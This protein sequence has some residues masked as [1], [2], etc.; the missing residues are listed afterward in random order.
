MR[1]SRF[2]AK[3]SAA[4]IPQAPE[5]W[6]PSHG[7]ASGVWPSNAH[8]QPRP[9]GVWARCGHRLHYTLCTLASHGSRTLTRRS[10]PS[11]FAST[12]RDKKRGLCFF[13]FF[14]PPFFFYPRLTSRADV[15]PWRRSQ[16]EPRREQGT[17]HRGQKHPKD[18][19]SESLILLQR[20]T[21][22]M[23]RQKRTSRKAERSFHTWILKPN[24]VYETIHNTMTASVCKVKK[25]Q[26][27]IRSCLKVFAGEKANPGSPIS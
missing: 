8:T 21:E 26:L 18:F 1:G 23:I 6:L 7:R 24:E 5:W 10:N 9:N 20:R 3:Q 19:F 14:P 13:F 12:A 2:R 4:A 11:S 25:R 17:S 16:R 22:W 27:F 15:T